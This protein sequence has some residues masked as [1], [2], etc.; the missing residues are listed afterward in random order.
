M[1]ILND[2]IYFTVSTA[3][4]LRENYSLTITCINKVI[5][6]FG[7]VTDVELMFTFNDD[8]GHK[9]KKITEKSKQEISDKLAFN[10][11]FSF[12][13]MEYMKKQDYFQNSDCDNKF[14]S[15]SCSI[16]LGNPNK[17]RG[18][19]TTFDGIDVSVP[20]ELIIK[21]NCF[22]KFN[23][24][25][26]EIHMLLCGVNSFISHGTYLPSLRIMNG[27]QFIRAYYTM[28]EKWDEFVCGYFWGN[29]LSKNHLEKLGDFEYINKQGFYKVE[30]WN[31]DVYIQTTQ[32]IFAYTINDAK[33]TR[34]FLLP[35]F[36]PKEDKQYSLYPSIEE[37]R[38]AQNAGVEN[39]MLEEDML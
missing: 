38:K 34:E 22:E 20:I 36:P 21:D 8:K 16:E 6:F 39:F 23:E 17:W 11:I 30:M 28:N 7:T 18:S 13:I 19:R 15:L 14:P 32:D 29:V 9:T 35:I 4:D 10:K 2:S 25:F 5:E 27:A 3:Q 12:G 1:K 33:K 26:K 24:L 31:D 37:L